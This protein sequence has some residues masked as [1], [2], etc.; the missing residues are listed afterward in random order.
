MEPGSKVRVLLVD[1]N[2]V[3]R[4]TMRDILQPHSDI[5]VVGEASDG[6]EAVACVGMLQPV[7]V[8]MD[9]NMRKMDGIRATRSIKTEYPHVLVLGYSADPKDYNAQQ[10]GAFEVLQ[11]DEAMK[12]LYGAIQK[13][14][15]AVQPVLIMEETP[16]SKQ[17]AEE[18]PKAELMSKTQ[19]T[20]EPETSEEGIP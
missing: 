11:R 9:M 18:S 13:A 5:E 15:A 3:V 7:L 20:E 12:D 2:L 10:V 19:S 6:D 4:Q 1:D 17:A 16:V 8:V 14:V